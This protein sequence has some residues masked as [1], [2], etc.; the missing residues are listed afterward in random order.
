M[1]RTVIWCIGFM[2]IATLLAHVHFSGSLS[3]LFESDITKITVLITFCFFVVSI[4]IGYYTYRCENLRQ[5]DSRYF[6]SQEFVERIGWWES[7]FFSLGFIGT[8]LG[9]AYLAFELSQ[10]LDSEAFDPQVA[11]RI[12]IP[13]IGTSITTTLVGL[14]ASLL[15][16]LQLRN[17][18]QIL[19]QQEVIREHAK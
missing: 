5:K 8:L 13:G 9:F 19:P 11:S 10:A 7:V 2:C 14:I 17:I 3:Y 6:V 18:Q 1:E 4:R 15:L 12:L 16:A